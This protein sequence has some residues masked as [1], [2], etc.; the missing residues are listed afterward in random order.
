MSGFHF[1]TTAPSAQL[2]RDVQALGS[3]PPAAIES[4]GPVLAAFLG[5]HRHQEELLAQWSAQQ[6]ALSAQARPCLTSL[7]HFFSSS[8]KAGA[9]SGAATLSA[10]A[11]ADLLALGLDKERVELL[12][13]HC[14]SSLS[15]VAERAL[16][17]TLQVSQ[18]Q[19]IS[20]KFGVSA[21]SSE[22][23][24]MG[25]CFLQLRLTL[26]Q[27]HGSENVL[28]GQRRSSML[29]ATMQGMQMWIGFTLCTDGIFRRCAFA[30]VVVLQ[31]CR[32]LSSINF[33]SRCSWPIDRCKTSAN[34]RATPLHHRLLV[35]MQQHVQTRP[36]AAA[37]TA[38]H[39]VHFA[40]S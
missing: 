17:R 39:S 27:G 15:D 19:D 29:A 35:R 37:A 32:F 40:P 5:Q 4:F 25:A 2:V 18:L 3:W 14:L 7:L 30:F 11:R 8:M 31:S 33:C 34:E 36:T 9:S 26:D 38:L 16:A 21:A 10:H 20:W 13:A 12:S 22:Q 23:D 24:K 6:P 1:T 28:M